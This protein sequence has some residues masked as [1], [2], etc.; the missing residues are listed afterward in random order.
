MLPLLQKSWN[1]CDSSKDIDRL[2]CL[3]C[4]HSCSKY[5]ARFFRFK[6]CF[7]QTLQIYQ[8][9]SIV[10]TLNTEALLCASFFQTTQ[11]PYC[12]IARK[13]TAVSLNWNIIHWMRFEVCCLFGT[14]P[15]IRTREQ[16]LNSSAIDRRLFSEQS[17]RSKGTTAER[18][19]KLKLL[20]H[21]LSRPIC[22]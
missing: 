21:N 7:Y 15:L 18:H 9:M 6:P 10:S 22:R 2:A 19:Q 3:A 13:F 5:K 4:L 12:S 11:Y 1:K 20:R 16:C 14:C 17:I 8:N